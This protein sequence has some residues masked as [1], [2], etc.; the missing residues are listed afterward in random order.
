MHAAPGK[1]RVIAAWIL[2]VLAALAFLMAGVSKLAGAP[3]MVAVFDQVGIGQWFRYLTGLL[4]VT[5]AVGLLIP[6]FTYYAALL[7]S[8]VM[9]GAILSHLT[10]VSGSP[11]AAIVLLL[12]TATIA[13]L[14][15]P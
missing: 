11:A 8:A 15:R 3:D 2:Q 4:E 1:G 14:R 9:I 5:G 7:L 6:R 12:I 10:V 13:W